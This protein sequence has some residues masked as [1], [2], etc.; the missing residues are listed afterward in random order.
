MHKLEK[1]IASAKIKTF[2]RIF[3]SNMQQKHKN[4]KCPAYLLSTKLL[5]IHFRPEGYDVPER[6]KKD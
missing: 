6:L 5:K 3:Y 4:K 1:S 2:C